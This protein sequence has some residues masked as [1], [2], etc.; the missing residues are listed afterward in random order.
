MPQTIKADKVKLD[1]EIKL[2]QDQSSVENP[3]SQQPAGKQAT[4]KVVESNETYAVIEVVCQCGAK[5]RI[6][7]KYA[8]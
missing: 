7:C 5:T 4:A 2:G 3:A 8:G 1:G 6:K